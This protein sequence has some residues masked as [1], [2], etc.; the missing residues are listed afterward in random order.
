MILPHFAKP[1]L[2]EVLLDVQ[3]EPLPKLLIPEIGALWLHLQGRF[4]TLEQH[5]PLDPVIERIGVLP[6]GRGPSI[7]FTAPP[8]I[9]RIWFIDESRRELIQI[10][11]DRF[12]RNWRRTDDSD[13]YPRYEKYIRPRFKRDFEDF[14]RFLDEREVGQPTATQ[15][16]L[17]YI[18]HIVADDDWHDHSQI[19]RI[20]SVCSTPGTNVAGMKFEQEQFVLTFLIEDDGR[21]VGR[22]RVD[23][24]PRF[25]VR[26]KT[27]LYVLKL[28]ARG[29][30]LKEGIE[31][32]MGFMDLGRKLIVQTFADITTKQLQKSWERLDA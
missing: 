15:C 21:F 2:V 29:R 28:T 31:G 12:I 10:Q 19:E 1:P 7:E 14:C 30:P 4:S 27:A 13:Q 18:N 3:F 8:P 26:D 17:T 9:P 16:E 6:S 23:A 5:P 20:F 25:R 22:L 11:Q 24:E 32:I